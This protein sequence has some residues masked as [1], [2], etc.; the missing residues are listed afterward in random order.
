MGKFFKTLWSVGVYFGE[1]SWDVERLSCSEGH[2]GLYGGLHL[3]CLSKYITFVSCNQL[4]N[5]EAPCSIWDRARPIFSR[6]R[7]VSFNSF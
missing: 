1:I 6:T 2:L 3:S 4:P 7:L 5:C